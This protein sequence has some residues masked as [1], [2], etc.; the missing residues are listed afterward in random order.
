MF[1][2]RLWLAPEL[3]NEGRTDEGPRL[4]EW[5]AQ[6]TRQSK[7]ILILANGLIRMAEFPKKESAVA[8]GPRAGIVSAIAKSIV[9]MD[10]GIIREDD[11]FQARSGRLELSKVVQGIAERPVGREI[12]TSVL[13]T[14]GHVDKLLAEASSGVEIRYYKVKVPQ[15]VQHREMLWR[16]TQ[17]LAQLQ[18][19]T[20]GSLHFRGRVAFSGHKRRAHCRQQ[21]QFAPRLLGA[22]RHGTKNFQTLSEMRDRLRV[23]RHEQG[24]LAGLQ[25]IVG[26]AIGHVRFTVMVRDYLGMCL[27]RLRET[28]FQQFCGLQMVLLAGPS[29]QRAVGG[30]LDQRVLEDI[31]RP[32]R[33]AALVEQFG[34]DQLPQTLLQQIVAG[35]GKTGDHFVGEF[36]TQHR[37]E[38]G[39]LTDLRQAIKTP[40]QRFLQRIG[41]GQR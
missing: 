6:L 7:A 12:K 3:M 41:N 30:I 37:T 4:A 40:H 5:M 13:S 9:T 2:G 20:I 35:G 25:V 10:R 18:R 11:L 27:D 17:F 34:V 19:S 26:R 15:T 22:V 23:C 32:G 38:L 1:W 8:Q 28:G 24:P 31:I 21:V 36:A 33:A 39:Q 16:V 14:L 29:Q